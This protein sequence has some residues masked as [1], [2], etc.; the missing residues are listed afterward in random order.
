M[1]RTYIV[2]TCAHADPTAGNE[3][4]DWLGELIYDI[5][6]DVVVDLGDFDDL[7]SLNTF[8][9]QYPKAI[10]G[11]SYAKDIEHG[12]EARD[13]LW[14]KY[15]MSKKKRPFRVG[16]EGNHEYRIKRAID[17]DPRIDGK[18]SNYGVS[19]SHLQTDYWYDE[20][21]EYSNSA[22]SLVD[23]DGITFGHYVA[24][25]AYGNALSGKHHAHALVER[26]SCSV[27]VGHSHELHYYRKAIARPN[28]INGLVAGCFKGK[29]ETWAG[30]SNAEWTKGVAIKREVSNGD[31]D[32][33][34]VSMRALQREYG[35]G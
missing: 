11:Q 34:F 33:Q 10:S 1:S 35:N 23:Y 25:G 20:Y 30:Q 7:R 12:Q 3:R 16:F 19:F 8:D 31:Y 4:F 9:G 32:L 18:G 21:H 22:P 5:K 17:K 14:R 29:E 6:P 13:R 28:P 24:S 27:T 15:R 2:W 26:L